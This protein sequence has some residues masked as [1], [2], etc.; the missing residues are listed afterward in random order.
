MAEGGLGGFLVLTG[1]CPYSKLE[2][3][4]AR[5]VVLMSRT[6]WARFFLAC[7]VFSAIIESFGMAAVLGVL[8]LANLILAHS[9]K[10]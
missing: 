8:A 4:L 2:L 7:A 3:A 9:V 10:D 5:K 6:N 1:G